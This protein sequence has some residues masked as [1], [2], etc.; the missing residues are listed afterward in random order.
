MSSKQRRKIAAGKHNECVE[1][2]REVNELY[3]KLFDSLPRNV[4]LMFSLSDGNDK[5]T[6]KK[7]IEYFSK[8]NEK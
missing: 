7:W 3:K 2:R 5:E 1:L 6:L 8:V 4:K